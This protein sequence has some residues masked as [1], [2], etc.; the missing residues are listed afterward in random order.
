[1]AEQI[2]PVEE[3]EKE[4]IE[5]VPIETEEVSDIDATPPPEA[6]IEEDEELSPLQ[7]YFLETQD[8]AQPLSEDEVFDGEDGDSYVAGSFEDHALQGLAGVIDTAQ[9]MG[10]MAFIPE[11]HKALSETVET[12]NLDSDKLVFNIKG[13]KNYD[14]D[15]PTISFMSDEEFDE[16][17]AQDKVSFMPSIAKS[18]SNTAN[19]TRNLSRVIAG[20][21]PAAK[22][23]K[24]VKGLSSPVGAALGVAKKPVTSKV[25]KGLQKYA[26]FTAMGTLGSVFAFKPYEARIADDMV[27]FVKDTPFEVTQPFFEW[28]SSADS[29]SEVEERFKIALEAMI[30]DAMLV[31]VAVPAFSTFFKVFKRERKLAKAEMA[32]AP[33]ED[34]Q[35]INDIEVASIN[36]GDMA[37]VI[38]PPSMTPVK[39][40][41]RNL[42]NEL[43]NKA[44][45]PEDFIPVGTKDDTISQKVVDSISLSSDGLK[46]A[47]QAIGKAYSSGDEVALSAAM[48]LTG[49]QPLI[50][51]KTIKDTGVKNII[52]AL[53][54][55]IDREGRL[56]GEVLTDKRGVPLRV[57][58]K[59]RKTFEQAKREAI[60][61][62][63][64]INNRS[65]FEEKNFLDL[66]DKLGVSSRELFKMMEPDKLMADQIG[67]RTLAWQMVLDDLTSQVGTALKGKD[68]SDPFIQT[69]ASEMLDVVNGLW[70]AFSEIPRGVGRALSQRR[71]M[72]DKK[73]LKKS[74]DGRYTPKPDVELSPSEVMARNAFLQKQ[75]KNRGMNEEMLVSLRGAMG[76][77]STRAERAIALR[78]GITASFKGRRAML[79]MYRGL[80][81]TNMKTLTTNFLGNTLET[82][83]IPLSRT[84]GH[85]ATLN[86]KGI[87]EELGFMANMVLSTKKATLGAWD[88]LINERNLLD[89][90]R[91]KAEAFDSDITT[92]FYMSMNKAVDAGYWHPQNWIPL[93][94]NAGGKLGRTSLRLLGAQDEFFKILT[95][96]GKAMSKIAE[97]LPEG[98]SRADKK[99]FISKHLDLFYDDAGEAVDRE[100]LEYSRRAAFQEDL[101]K[102]LI[103]DLHLAIARTPELGIFFPFVRTPANLMSRAL[104]RTPIANVMSKRTKR[105]W[106]SGNKSERAEVI[107]N[108]IIGTGLFSAALGY[109]MSGTITGSGPIDPVRNRLW[110][111]AG[112]KPYHIK[113]GDT[114]RRYDRLEPLMLPFIYVSS[115]HENLYRYNNNQEDLEDSILMFIAVSAKTLV[116]RTWLRGLKGIVDGIDSA[117]ANND[118][119][120]LLSSIIS[121]VVPSGINQIYR[122]SGLPDEDSGIYAYREARGWQEKTMAKLPP[123]EGYDA[124][125]H[126]WLTGEPMLIPS[127]GDFGLD[128]HK[129]E[130]SRY[131]EEL[132]R[133][134][135]NIHGVSRKI[136]E[137]ELS[138]DQYSRLT[139]L[140]GTIEIEGLTLMEQLEE[141][142][143]DPRYDFDETRTYHPDF[144]SPQQKAVVKIINAYKEKARFTLLQE[145]PVLH[146]EWESAIEE[147][148]KVGMGIE[149]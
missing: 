124:V 37:D 113:I 78:K 102:G 125:K 89:P 67:S 76:I 36:S 48:E 22:V 60:P 111:S 29:D 13:F 133:F 38:Y 94:V 146:E 25:A 1:M 28:M 148:G 145:D 32:G 101:E 92:G 121:N 95:Y 21:V 41:A 141:I 99:K 130:P 68:L 112:F 72:M 58:Q 137:V 77:G 63:K 14:P 27:G 118:K 12:F 54:N 117:V 140:T 57:S 20:L 45:N 149:Q 65:S 110:R 108:T 3:E 19:L 91:T 17:Y 8:E 66:K 11:M 75:M 98:L 59:S 49:R 142:M 100:L 114:W 85:M 119:N 86:T 18:T 71:I 105:M 107:G 61:Y 116:D 40:E 93:L 33:I 109:S 24:G 73:F 9:N 139:E 144:K 106:N 74:K 6:P 96:N 143:D 87:K 138:S 4:V 64:Y 34:L 134:G 131:M 50:N 44:S 147:K 103:N 39:V 16:L 115:L 51:I 136:G 62:A 46:R 88:T 56:L 35:A 47:V 83:L 5:E 70:T 84:I 120:F 82:M 129:E 7:R 97:S 42:V 2:V 52:N 23:L 53:S 69:Q 31:G 10:E 55:E 128:S 135:N 104:Q 132:L 80:L 123:S 43:K 90:L 81:L 15:R 127:G 30:I 122:L 79:E 126:N 26:D